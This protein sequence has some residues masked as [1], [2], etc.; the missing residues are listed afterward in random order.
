MFD[1]YPDV[2]DTLILRELV[3]LHKKELAPA[4]KAERE[5]RNARTIL[6]DTK[7]K[8]ANVNDKIHIQILEK[9]IKELEAKL[10]EG[11]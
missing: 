8:E 2:P 1:E 10:S 5:D 11:E 4:I 3:R 9:K 6:A 7:C